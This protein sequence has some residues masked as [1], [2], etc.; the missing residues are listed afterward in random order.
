MV[1]QGE[2]LAVVGGQ[3][4]SEGKGVIVA[5]IMNEWDVHVRVGAPNAGHSF[6]HSNGKIYKM[7]SIP[8]GWGNPDAKLVIG[9][10]ALVNPKIFLRELAMVEEVDPNIKSRLFIDGAAGVLDESFHELEGGINGEMHKRIGSTGEGVGPARVAR[11]NR[12]PNKFKLFRDVAGELG[13][14]SLVCE[15]TPAMLNNWITQHGLSV[16]LEG[17]QGCGLSLLHGHWPYVTSTDTNAAQLLADTGIPPAFLTYT[18]VVVRTYPIRV[19]GTSGPLKGEISWDEMSRRIGKP[20]EEKTTVTLKT[21][22]VAEWD[23]ELMERAVILNAPT[24][25]ALTFV[26]Y[27][28]PED[29]GKDDFDDLSVKSREFVTKIENMANCPCT[30]IGTGG[31]PWT[32]ID[33]SFL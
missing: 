15:D 18:M 9:R 14:G 10:G 11:I 25:L 3:Y 22:R 30:L 23:D 2:V 20:V 31:E 19:A 33:R 24:H 8:V 7:Q 32:V 27:I 28:S 4:G 12:D 13:L 21:R 26:D 5:K 17:S 1:K 29:E 16:L 6:V